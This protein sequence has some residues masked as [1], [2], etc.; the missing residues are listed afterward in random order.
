MTLTRYGQITALL[1]LMFAILIWNINQPFFGHHEPNGIWIS[2][3]VR[4]WNWYGF[5]ELGGLPVTTAEPADVDEM[6]RYI[7]HPPLMVWLSLIASKL[8]GESDGLPYAMSMRLVSIFS[9]M[10]S[11]SAFYVVAR[12]LLSARWALL[13]VA[14]YGLTPMIGY[15]GRMPNHEPLALA[16]LF[17]FTAI[18][19]NWLRCY[20]HAR[21]LAMLILAIATMWTAW[22][23][24]FFF[25]T[26]GIVALVL[27]KQQ[28][29]IAIIGIGAITVLATLAIFGY[30][31]WQWSGSITDL[32]DAFF[33][34]ASSATLAPESES[35]TFWSFVQTWFIHMLTAM[36]F[37]VVLLA[38]V[39]LPLV[40]RQKTLPRAVILA[41]WVAPFLYMLTFRNA[42][43]VHDYY[44]IYYL[45]GFV[46][47]IGVLLDWAWQ[48]RKSTLRRISRPLIVGIWVCSLVLGA[49]WFW[50]L[51]QSGSD[52]FQWAIVNGLQQHTEVGDV[53]Y[54]DF[55]RKAGL[56]YYA[57]RNFEWDVNFT[58]LSASEGYALICPDDGDAA[59]YDGVLSDR[60]FQII[61]DGACRLVALVR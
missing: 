18:F 24:A 21:S 50:T 48:P 41:L 59:N 17:T 53:I 39:A 46:L 52:D 25:V 34:R 4:N 9:T 58:R 60:A 5:F 57:Y 54:S 33:Y 2:T 23:G 11:L 36:T 40:L 28:H 45:A 10:V 42:F 20:S 13:C 3:S 55:E 6:L 35:F 15:F 43:N 37:G 26:L 38:I 27:G 56:E 44:K 1:L 7:H 51:H 19:I 49:F 32:I 47:A 61:A 8:F 14:F 12:R 30:Y 16:L 29:R 31:E 22:A